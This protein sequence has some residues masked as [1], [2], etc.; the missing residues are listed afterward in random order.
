LALLVLLISNLLL[1]STL[2]N[3]KRERKCGAECC[4]GDGSF[5]ESSLPRQ[6]KVDD[7]RAK[8]DDY[9]FV[10]A[11]AN[12]KEVIIRIKISNENWVDDGDD[13]DGSRRFI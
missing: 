2:D 4:G 9:G 6:E 3:L 13:D 8:R 12:E 10:V 1:L 7:H 5:G 11:R